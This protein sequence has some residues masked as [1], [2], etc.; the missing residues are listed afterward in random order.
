MSEQLTRGWRAAIL[1]IASVLLSACGGDGEGPGKCYTP[2]EPIC[3]SLGVEI[4]QPEVRSSPVGL[5]RGITSNGRA[6][7]GL[8]LDDN[9][10][11]SIYS[12]INNPG[13]AGGAI[14]G[15]I[16]ASGGQ[17]TITDAV[18]VNLEGLGTQVAAVSGS[19]AP[20]QSINGMITYPLSSQTV[21]FTA[22][23]SSDYEVPASLSAIAGT[24]SG[25]SGS[26]AGS[27]RVTL[28][29]SSAGAITGSGSSGCALSGTISPRSTGNTYQVTVTFG[30]A[31]CRLPGASL[32]GIAYFDRSAGLTYTIVSPPGSNDK[33]VAILAKQ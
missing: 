6:V 21:S 15:T 14:Q 8:I 4:S 31:P 33:F 5:Y 23:Y 16:R 32:S 2:T 30:A 13:V 28:Q 29:I 22:N 9:S 20:K 19:Y 26:A 25:T 10:F 12:G 11:Y 3:R 24:H 27:E 1:A 18:D 17:Y 7:A